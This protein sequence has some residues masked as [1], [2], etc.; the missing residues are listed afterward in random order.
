M[1]TNRQALLLRE[2]L[3]KGGSLTCLLTRLDLRNALLIG[4]VATALCF[5]ASC[6]N[7]GMS[8]SAANANTNSADT[9]NTN[10]TSSRPVRDEAKYKELSDKKDELA[11]LAPPL[12]LD[13]KARI[14]GKVLLVGNLNYKNG[15]GDEGISSLRKAE[16]LEELETLIQVVCSKGK[17]LTNYEKGVKGYA[18]DCKVSLIDYR[19]PAVIAQKNFSN[20]ERE[21]V[22]RES[23]VRDNE[24]VAPQPIGDIRSYIDSLQVDQVMPM[25]ILL[26]EKE[27]LRV[28][29]AVNL[30]PNA[31]MK[32]KIKIVDKYEEGEIHGW[33][34][35]TKMSNVEMYGLPSQKFTYNPEELETLIRVICSKGSLI[36]KVG[37]RTEYSNKC[38]VSLIDYKSLTVFAQQ[39]FE[40]KELEPN[41][42]QGSL[43]VNWVVKRPKQEIED[44]LK[45]FPTS[46]G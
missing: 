14:K 38:E 21:E 17:F 4:I 25:G 10:S 13:P 41:A 23:D 31:T 28:A 44:Y 15:H 40:N 37:N 36:G 5:N 18:S 35:Y 2:S 29:A 24:Y 43:P 39:T 42:T 1:K 26:D 8:N 30:N 12:K 9:P 19:A 3:K 6:K 11:K 20:S 34:P 7:N 32:G 16:S 45:R 33:L 27:L 46:P 22:I